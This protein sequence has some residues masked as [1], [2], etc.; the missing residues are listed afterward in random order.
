M[1][2]V[3]WA[4]VARYWRFAGALGRVALTVGLPSSFAAASLIWTGTSIPGAVAAVAVVGILSALGYGMLQFAE[5]NPSSVLEGT[6]LLQY[7]VQSKGSK[8]ALPK[9]ATTD[10]IETQELEPPTVLP[11]VIVDEEEE[12][13]E[14]RQNG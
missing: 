2:S 3:N 11:G 7:M 14:G 8:P 6:E 9:A 10:A 4:G 1:A 13:D 5:R 12:E